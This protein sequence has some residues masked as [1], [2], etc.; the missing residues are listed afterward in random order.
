MSGERSLALTWLER[1]AHRLLSPLRL[2]ELCFF[3]A[4]KL[5]DV[6]LDSVPSSHTASGSQLTHAQ[7]GRAAAAL[8]LLRA[9]ERWFTWTFTR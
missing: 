4:A 7:P 2:G 8:L 1:R 3:L 6:R 9:R 5:Q